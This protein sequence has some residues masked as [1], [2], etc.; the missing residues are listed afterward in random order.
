MKCLLTIRTLSFVLS[1]LVAVLPLSAQQVAK[2]GQEA[3]GEWSL[4]VY[5]YPSSELLGGFVSSEQGQLTAPAL[6]A[7][8]ASAEDVAKF[9]S[10]I[11]I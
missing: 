1:S 7:A 6:P 2:Q 5:R 8:N 9:L 11:H 10:L 3:Q 4:R